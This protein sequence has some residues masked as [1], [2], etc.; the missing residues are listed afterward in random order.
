MPIRDL[1]IMYEVPQENGNRN[2]TR[3]AYIRSSGRHGLAVS[4]STEFGFKVSNKIAGL[5]A[6]R[7]PYEVVPSEDWILGVDYAQH[8]LG[9]QACG[10]G[11]LEPYRLKMSESG[12]EF[13]V[14]LKVI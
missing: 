5:E 8:G 12:W 7:H 10:P 13:E 2:G 11:V 6:A 1:D 4:A 3:W 9:T 14:E